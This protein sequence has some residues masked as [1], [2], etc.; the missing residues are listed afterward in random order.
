[1]MGKS[2][3]PQRRPQQRHRVVRPSH[4]GADEL[5][6]VAED[7]DDSTTCSRRT[8]IVDRRWGDW[9]VL[10]LVRGCRVGGAVLAFDTEGVDMLERRKDLAILWDIRVHP[11]SAPRPGAPPA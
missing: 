7:D 11:S 10:F 1:M 2:W 8:S 6:Y 4:R 5:E 9:S 3:L